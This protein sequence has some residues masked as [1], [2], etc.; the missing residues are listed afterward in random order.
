[1]G[2]GI[3]RH[4]ELV[5]SVQFPD[6]FRNPGEMAT[7]MPVTIKNIGEYPLQVSAVA[8]EGA[9]NW[10]LVEQPTSFEIGGLSSHDVLVAF[11]PVTAGKA[12]D[13]TLAVTSDDRTSP[14]LNVVL[15]GNG[16]DR[17]V[18]MGPGALD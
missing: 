8:L 13:A 14:L 3:D 2:R 10:Q 16:K 5:E 7:I 6:T 4:I 17:N 1:T 18:A 11:Q 15:S 12:P 9:P